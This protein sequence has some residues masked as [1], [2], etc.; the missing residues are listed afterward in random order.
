MPEQY[1]KDT[2][3]DKAFYKHFFDTGK[4]LKAAGHPHELVVYPGVM[5]AF[6]GFS[7][8]IDEARRMIDDLARFLGEHTGGR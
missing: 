3:V 2:V 8:M 4:K 5:H 7:S 1:S 6:F